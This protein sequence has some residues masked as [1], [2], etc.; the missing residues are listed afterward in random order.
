MDTT[1]CVDCGRT[2]E[3][4]ARRCPDCG[5]ILQVT[6]D[7]DAVDLTPATLA[8]RPFS[9]I[10]RYADLLPTGP[11]VTMAE[12]ATPLV[13]APDLADDLGV[14]RVLLKDEGR[15]PTNAVTD[16]E[17]ALGIT[18]ARDAGA[19]TVALPSTGD[20][21]QSAAAYAARAGIDLEAFVPSRATFLTKALINVH[22]GALSVTGGRLPDA[23]A[24]FAD[25]I[26]EQSWHSLAPFETPYRQAGLRTLAYELAEQLE[27][28]V[29]D[30]IVYPTGTG[31]GPVG[32][33]QGLADLRALGWIDDTPQL[34]AA[35]A[36]GCAPIVRAWE[37]GADDHEP[38]DHPDTICGGIE[39]PDP[40]GSRLVLDALEVTDGGA[41]ATEDDA[42]LDAAT[43][44]AQTAGI[45]MSATAG[46]AASGARELADRGAFDADDTVVLVNTAAGAK[47]DDLLRS[48]LMSKGI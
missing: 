6:T 44:V 16:R 41:V 21:A 40:T 4:P 25:A 31:M 28:T 26:A 46:A 37:A 17:M 2:V 18:A 13:A 22:G 45:E 19:E 42:I 8:D 35:Q 34:F 10:E 5:G 23:E 3:A 32:I 43:T 20:S 33:E 24:A 1:V 30:A 14:E 27:W 48:H 47:E 38:W 15:N 9:G 29:P 39:V 36:S 11:L 12:G 7:L